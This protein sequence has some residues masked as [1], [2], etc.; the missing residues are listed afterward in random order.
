MA[1]LQPVKIRNITLGT[2]RPK[3]AVPITG[4]TEQE[5]IAQAQTIKQAHPGF[6]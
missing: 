6:D 4:I 5:I 3:I 1:Q 2:G